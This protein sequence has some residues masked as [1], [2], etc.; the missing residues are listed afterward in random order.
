MKLLT[1]LLFLITANSYSSDMMLDSSRELSDLMYLPKA[2]TTFV[3]VDYLSTQST[4]DL[5]Y[6]SRNFYSD[7]DTENTMTFNIGGTVSDNYGWLVSIPYTPNSKSKTTY[8]PAHVDDGETSTTE[9]KGLN[10]IALRFKYR[11]AEQ[12]ESKSNMDINVSLSP[13]SGDAESGSTSKDGNE[14]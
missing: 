4:A 9:S 1:G 13:K 7:D 3:S 5:E 14:K 12:T 6:Q 10:D 11:F 8:G 2:D